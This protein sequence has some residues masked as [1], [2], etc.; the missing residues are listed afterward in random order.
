M[1]SRRSAWALVGAA[2]VSACAGRGKA[3]VEPLVATPKSGPASSSPRPPAGQPSSD[4]PSSTTAPVPKPRQGY[5]HAPI[6]VRISDPV[7]PAAARERGVHGTV[8]V[9]FVID[10]SGRVSSARVLQS[11]PELDA[12]ALD[13]VRSWVFKPALRDGKAVE[14]TARAPVRF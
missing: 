4:K 6:P 7:S 14:T 12:A 11:V 1:A 13:C 8:L 2:L 5:D 10:A 3:T 9:E